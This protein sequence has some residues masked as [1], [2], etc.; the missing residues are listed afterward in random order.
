MPYTYILQCADGSLYTGWT[1][2]LEKRIIAHNSGNGARYTRG[3]V[4][5][6]LV[7]WEVQPTRSM[8]QRREENIKK[9]ERCKKEELIAQFS[10]KQQLQQKTP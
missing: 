9:L 10:V 6:S 7:Y 3:R 2:D 4:P 5:V 8:A 1:T